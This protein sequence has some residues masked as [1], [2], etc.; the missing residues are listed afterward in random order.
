[1]VDLHS[2]ECE[3]GVHTEC[4]DFSA[5]QAVLRFR[6]HLAGLDE[7]G[8]RVRFAVYASCCC[9][10]TPCICGEPPVNISTTLSDSTEM[11]AVP[12][13]VVVA[14]TSVEESSVTVYSSCCCVGTLAYLRRVS[15][16]SRRCS[17]R[18]SWVTL[19]AG[20]HFLSR[21]PLPLLVLDARGLSLLSCG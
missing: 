21:C 1:M 18:V 13:E 12:A 5:H 6:F 19:R 2:P 16:C 4:K 10:G 17:A 11:S 9:V 20:P 14:K 15:N 8:V 3:S 7:D